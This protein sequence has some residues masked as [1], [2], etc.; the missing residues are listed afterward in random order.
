MDGE[1][2]TTQDPLPGTGQASGGDAGPSADAETRLTPAQ[3][4]QLVK[5]RH[6]KLDT[7][8]HGLETTIA[9]R[10]KELTAI[11]D[12]RKSLKK[13][14]D[15]LGSKDPEAFNL[16]KKEQEL[17]ERENKLRDDRDA[18]TKDQETNKDRLALAADTLMEIEVWDISTEYEGGHA[19]KLKDLCITFDAKTPEQIRKVADT[20][21]QRKQGR[22]STVQ[23]YS[24]VTSGGGSESLEELVKKPAKNMTYEERLAHQAKL[25]KLRGKKV[26]TA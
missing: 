17:R 16:V 14:I 22:A 10:D 24:G 3:V 6:S 12:E 8:I 13:Q 5:E 2:N 23:P 26:K 4:D 18:L 15:E 25:D 9:D 7:K 20:L 21:W 11:R 19:V 1:D